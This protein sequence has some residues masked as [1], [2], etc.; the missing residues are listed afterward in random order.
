MTDFVPSTKNHKNGKYW[1][2][3][4]KEKKKADETYDK[5]NCIA[6]LLSERILVMFFRMFDLVYDLKLQ[7]ATGLMCL[8]T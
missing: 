6:I 8:E 7:P 1:A 4:K 5:L 2:D 3:G